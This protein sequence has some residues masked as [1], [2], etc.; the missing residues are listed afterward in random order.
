MPIRFGGWGDAGDAGVATLH[1]SIARGYVDTD[2][3]F[4]LA[5][6]S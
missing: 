2:L 1:L 5:Y 4:R 6:I 3:G